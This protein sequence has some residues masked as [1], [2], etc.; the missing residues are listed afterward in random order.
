MLSD[1]KA[2][3]LRS[4]EFYYRGILIRV[5]AFLNEVV[6]YKGDYFWNSLISKY[7]NSKYIPLSIHDVKEFS[8]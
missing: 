6:R 8:I 7:S 1:M 2:P 5:P 3:R 4:F